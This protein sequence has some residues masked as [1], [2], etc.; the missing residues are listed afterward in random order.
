MTDRPAS[1]TSATARATRSRFA[2]PAA[3]ATLLPP[4][5]E[6]KA[7]P[8]KKSTAKAKPATKSKAAKGTTTKAP[9]KKS[10]SSSSTAK[11]TSAN[12]LI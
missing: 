11:S 1:P 2:S 3:Q 7:A 6:K 5:V 12:F 4:K 9:A 10:S 8:A